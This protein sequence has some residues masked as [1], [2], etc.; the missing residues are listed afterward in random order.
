MSSYNRRNTQQLEPPKKKPKTWLIV[1]IIIG[2]IILLAIIIVVIILL[3]RKSSNTPTPSGPCTSALDCPPN[4]FC[5]NG[6]CKEC[7]ENADCVGN[8]TR[9]FC[10]TTRG[11][12]VVCTVNGDCPTATPYC[13]GNAACVQCLTNANCPTGQVCN[14]SGTCITLSGG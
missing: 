7:L 12:C 2:S 1:L 3:T 4:F 11:V 6:S 8:A 9:K 10:E 5:V 13:R 14:S